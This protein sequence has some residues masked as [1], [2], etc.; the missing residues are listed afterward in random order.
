M[1]SL[2]PNLNLSPRAARSVSLIVPSI[3]AHRTLLAVRL[4][5]KRSLLSVLSSWYREKRHLK[6]DA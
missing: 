3:D 1:T 5:T 2:L 4:V 6:N